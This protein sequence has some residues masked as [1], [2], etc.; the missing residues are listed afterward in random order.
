MWVKKTLYENRFKISGK[1]FG[2][3]SPL[4]MW[5]VVHIVYRNMRYEKIFW[6]KI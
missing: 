5:G 4:L 1:I 2:K 3:K 6:K